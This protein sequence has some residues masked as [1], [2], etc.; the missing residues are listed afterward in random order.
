MTKVAKEY[1]DGVELYVC[2]ADGEKVAI[3]DSDGRPMANDMLTASIRD[4]ITLAVKNSSNS[5]LVAL[6]KAMND[7][8]TLAQQYFQYKTDNIA[9]LYNDVDSLVSDDAF[10]AYAKVL[11]KD[12]T[13]SLQYYGSSLLLKDGTV[14]RHYFKL[15]SGSIKD[16]TVTVSDGESEPTKCTLKKSGSY[17]YVEFSVAAK[18][19]AKPYHV[20]VSNADGVHIAI[21]YS[22]FSYVESRIHTTD[23]AQLKL[24]MKSMY[25]YNQ[26]AIEYFNNK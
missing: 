23:D 22:A 1:G 8:C 17:Y 16:W 26:A 5:H 2:T 3:F 12:G 20:E 7:Y 6:V 10:D 15:N 18:N 9:P 19:L 25:L 21:D 13:K 14:I 11:T 4:Y 24:L